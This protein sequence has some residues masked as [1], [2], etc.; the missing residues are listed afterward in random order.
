MKYLL[1]I[2]QNPEA[3]WTGSDEDRAGLRELVDLKWK[4]AESGE[5]V[6]TQALRLP[7]ATKVV[8]VR[9]GVPAVTDGP[10]IEAKEHLAGYF[11]VDCASLD[12]AIEIAASTPVARTFAMEVRP[13]LDQ[14]EVEAEA[15]PEG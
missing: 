4:L 15:A 11:L 7:E 8:R 3:P 6:D 5:L 9:D 1:L 13:V 2:Y 10:F 12:R 14:A